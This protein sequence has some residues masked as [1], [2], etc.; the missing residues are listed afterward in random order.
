MGKT[1][2]SAR[3]HSLAPRLAARFKPSAHSGTRLARVSI[4]LVCAVF[5]AAGPQALE[6]LLHN[7]IGLLAWKIRAT[8]ERRPI[9]CPVPDTAPPQ[10][11]CRPLRRRTQTPGPPSVSCPPPGHRPLPPGAQPRHHSAPPNPSNERPL[12]RSGHRGQHSFSILARKARAGLRHAR[13]H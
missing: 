4:K 2:T 1:I 11:R 10:F 5:R 12:A 3:S 8:Q 13:P 7:G 9:E 6:E